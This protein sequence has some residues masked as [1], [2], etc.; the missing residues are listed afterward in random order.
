MLE[1]RDYQQRIVDEVRDRLK[2]GVRSVLIQ[3][4]T[5]G[6]KTA[7]TAK[8]IGTAA[9]RDYR[10]WFT[11][12]RRELIRQS[13]RTFHQVEIPH[14]VIAAQAPMDIRR[15][16][17][18]GSIQTLVRR[19]DRLPPPDLI[20]WDEA[21]HLAAGTWAKIYATYPDAI[22]IG[23]SATPERLDGAGLAPFFQE[24]VRGPSVRELI[25]AGYLS[26]F[27]MFSMPSVSMEGVDR[28]GGDFK[29]RDMVD[30]LEK[31][32]IIGDAVSHYVRHA[33]GR[34]GI[35]FEAS[36]E[37][38][39][40]AAEAFRAAGVPALH[41]DGTTDPAVRDRAMADLEAGRLKILTNVDLFGEGVDVPA[42]EVIHCCRPTDSLALWLQQCGRGLR[43][44][45]GK[46]HC[47]IFDHAGNLQRHGPPDIERE[48]TLAGHKD[49]G[50]GK[51]D[52]P[53]PRK[54]PHCFADNAPGAL[55]CLECRRPFPVQAREIEQVE[56]EL[57]EVEVAA[58]RRQ[59][60]HEQ[61]MAEDYE[62]LVRL[63]RMRGYRNPEGWAEHVAR[64]RVKAL[65]MKGRGAQA[66]A[67][68]AQLPGRY[69]VRA[70]A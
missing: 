41:V 27:R 16:V 5:G 12:H 25:D 47:L 36:V 7:L 51:G 43:P 20:A 26:A 34:R 48:W 3:L 67:L 58:M 23:L 19:L 8:M 44:S 39:E 15:R 22:H 32:T 50:R 21:H 24:M 68:E 2:A 64:G 10:A 45:P 57:Q 31:S 33:M 56:G 40:R 46:D 37:R 18:I 49:E 52:G 30:R 6:G 17:Q 55:V 9:R 54:C 63:G 4:P 66:D 65:R 28:Q 29:R 1:L 61:S 53:G 14:G 11:V 42:I 62:S 60:A 69:A 38:S 70:R 35:V 59:A 13:T